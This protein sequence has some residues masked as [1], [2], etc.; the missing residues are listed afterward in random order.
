M[1]PDDEI[2][3]SVESLHSKQR[4][5]F[6]VVHTWDTDYVKYDGHDVEP[7]HVFLLGS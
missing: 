1:L 3:E 4:E 5:V 6:D 7:V 2:A